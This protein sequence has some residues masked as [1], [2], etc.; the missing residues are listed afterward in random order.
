MKRPRLFVELFA[1]SAAVTLQLLGGARLGPPVAYMGSKRGYAHAILGALGLA[2][3]MG[4]DAVFL[5][6]GGPWGWVWQAL[7]DAETA[8]NVVRHLRDW[9]D[10]DPTDLWRRLAAEPPPED[11]AARTAS[12]LWLQGRGVSNTPI[13]WDG[14][15]WTMPTA[16]RADRRHAGCYA[17]SPKGAAQRGK[18][19]HGS[20]VGLQSTSTVADRVE[21][22]AAFLVLQAGNHAGK[23]VNA[24]EG[25]WLVNGFAHLAT[26]ARDRGFTERFRTDRVGD[27]VAQLPD[28]LGRSLVVANTDVEAAIALLPEDLTD[29][30]VYLDP[31][32][33]GCTRYACECDREKVVAIARH[34]DECGAVVAI[35]EAVPLRELGWHEMEITG[36][37]RGQARTASKVKREFLTLNRQPEERIAVQTALWPSEAAC[38]I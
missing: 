17:A 29:C 5:C 24:E 31:P 3:G 21:A 7:A 14:K 9:R 30:V 8:Q 23:P 35:S 16:P 1:G 22:I 10:D 2:P 12:V 34:L 28:S 18:W 15:R 27:R 38:S 33:V 26:S 13:W 19:S 25:R 4:A 6:D 36:A 37:R 20:S 32:Y 11:L